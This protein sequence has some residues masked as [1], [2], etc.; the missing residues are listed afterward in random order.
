[1]S[2]TFSFFI[3]L[4]KE[5]FVFWSKINWLIINL[6]CK[7]HYLL[8]TCKHSIHIQVNQLIFLMSDK[9]KIS[10][11]SHIKVDNSI[12]NQVKHVRVN[13][14]RSTC[15]QSFFT[16]VVS[17]FEHRAYWVCHT[18]MWSC[19]WSGIEKVNSG[20]NYCC[21]CSIKHLIMMSEWYIQ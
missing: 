19:R 5:H 15:M 10:H 2:S 20:G 21:L 16:R 18:H 17:S 8:Y 14:Y 9:I 12:S 6:L 13:F 11:L 1:M 4:I 7:V 3:V